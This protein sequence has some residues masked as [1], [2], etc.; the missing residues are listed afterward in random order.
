MKEKNIKLNALILTAALLLI[1]AGCSATEPQGAS[2]KSS[3]QLSGAGNSTTSSS[4]SSSESSQKAVDIDFVTYLA[5]NSLSSSQSYDIANAD[6]NNAV[7]CT[8]YNYILGDNFLSNGSGVQLKPPIMATPTNT[9]YF[10]ENSDIIFFYGVVE[11]KAEFMTMIDNA[12]NR[13]TPT[14][15]RCNYI[16]KDPYMI[17]NSLII[18]D[19]II[20]RHGTAFL[21]DY[22]IEDSALSNW[23]TNNDSFADR[24]GNVMRDRLAVGL[25]SYN[26]L[27]IDK[28]NLSGNEIAQLKAAF[29]I[30]EIQIFTG[31]VNDDVYQSALDYIMNHARCLSSGGSPFGAGEE[32]NYNSHSGF[33]K[34]ISALSN[35]IHNLKGLKD[36]N[37]IGVNYTP[38]GPIISNQLGL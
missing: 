38:L 23:F 20:Y 33:L 10:V 6:L 30:H 7:D 16:N 14:N 19:G 24:F 27:D 28:S 3:S 17:D 36:M 26:Y 11:S 9:K 34:Q 22:L 31:K 35:T 29:M 4:S 2:G 37:V 21:E 13:N 1:L 32:Y 15:L 18:G 25:I 5:T 12:L 8:N